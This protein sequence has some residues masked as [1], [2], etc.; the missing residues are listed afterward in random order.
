MY[1]K[2]VAGAAVAAALGMSGLTIGAGLAAATPWKS[3]PICAICGSFAD[4]PPPGPGSGPGRVPVDRADGRISRTGRTR[5]SRTWWTRARRTRCGR[6]RWLGRSSR[7]QRTGALLVVRA[8]DRRLAAPA[9]GARWTWRP[10]W[11]AATWWTGWTWRS[12]WP[13]WFG[14]TWW[15]GRAWRPGGTNRAARVARVDLVDP[16]NLDRVEMAGRGPGGPG[17]RTTTAAV[18]AAGLLRPGWP[19][20][21]RS[22]RRA[23]RLQR[24]RPRC[25]AT[26]P[27]AWVRLERRASSRASSAELGRATPSRWLERPAASRRLE[28]AVERPWPRHSSGAGRLRGLQLRWL[29]RHSGVQPALRWLGL[30]VLRY[31]DSAL[32][33]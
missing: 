4:D 17:W 27:T 10:G 25:S 18:C 33:T 14:W 21:R 1:V 5:R 8:A 2:H 3:A 30:L 15:S 29:Q 24:T 22:S 28:R 12:G 19:G 6:A 9:G 20:I 26:A 7:A 23:A 31:L 13:R 32:L 16:V 11:P